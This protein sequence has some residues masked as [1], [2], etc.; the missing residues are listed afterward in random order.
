M[1]CGFCFF[2]CRIA[3]DK[4]YFCILKRIRNNKRCEWF[5]ESIGILQLPYLSDIT[6]KIN[7]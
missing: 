2:N 6:G 4:K 3:S 5:I 1:K 7:K